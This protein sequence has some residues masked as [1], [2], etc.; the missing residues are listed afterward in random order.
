MEACADV[1]LPLMNSG[2]FEEREQEIIIRP[3]SHSCTFSFPFYLYYFLSHVS[4][5]EDIWA[6]AE[7][8]DAKSSYNYSHAK[9]PPNLWQLWELL[10]KSG[11]I[12]FPRMDFLE[13]YFKS[14][15]SHLSQFLQLI[16]VEILMVGC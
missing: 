7:L 9:A 16:Y 3:N 14:C 1:P 13:M 2:R 5:T 12:H 8:W 15:Q 11:V 10:P 6:R 4:I